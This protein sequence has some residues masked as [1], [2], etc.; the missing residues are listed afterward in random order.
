MVFF[1][2]TPEGTTGPLFGAAST[3]P[4]ELW[5]REDST[6][7]NHGSPSP[8]SPFIWQSP[9]LRPALSKFETTE[10]PRNSS[11][12]WVIKLLEP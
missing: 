3:M 4:F 11:L 8:D 12:Y 10:K 9:K 1:V 6:R 2:V 5:S 7:V